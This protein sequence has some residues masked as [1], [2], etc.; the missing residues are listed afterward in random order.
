MYKKLLEKIKEYKNI[1][2]FRHLRPDGDAIFS[3]LALYNFIKDNFTDKHVKMCGLDEYD[4]MPYSNMPSEKFIKSSLVIV[5]DTATSV[6][7]DNGLFSLGD[8]VVKI[9]HH[10]AIDQYG[11]LN[12]SEENRSS[13]CELLA[14]IL[15]SKDFKKYVRSKMVCTYLLSGILTDSNSFSTSNTSYKTLEIASKLTKESEADLSALNNYLFDLDIK[16]LNTYTA[17]RNKLIVKKGVG[18][19]ILDTDFLKK[20]KI[21]SDDAKNAIDEFSH[22]KGL[23]I[24]AIFAQNAKTGLFDASIRSNKSFII[25]SICTKYGGGGHKNA[26]GIKNLTKANINKLLKEFIALKI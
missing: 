5:L 11:N 14:N 17:I 2:I 18:Y 25:N 7:C 4:L 22:V 20:H 12:Y 23:H 19:V 3:Q 16:T 6:R 13:T 24:W 26:C 10:P 15:Y 1:C 21:S 9:D 8:Y